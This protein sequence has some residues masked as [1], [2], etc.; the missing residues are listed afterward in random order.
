MFQKN[1]NSIAIIRQQSAGNGNMTSGDQ[2]KSGT[3]NIRLFY[4]PVMSYHQVVDVLQM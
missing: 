3:L 2:L 4:F 1:F